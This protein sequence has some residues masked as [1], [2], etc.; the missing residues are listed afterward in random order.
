MSM[1]IKSIQQWVE[2]NPFIAYPLI[3]IIVLGLVGLLVTPGQHPMNQTHVDMPQ[4]NTPIGLG[5][6]GVEEKAYIT[7]LEKSSY[8]F[9][10]RLKDM[11]KQYQAMKNI[12]DDLKKKQDEMNKSSKER[13]RK[14]EANINDRFQMLQDKI[15]IEH[16]PATMQPQADIQLAIADIKPIEPDNNGDS[17][18][19][20]LGSFCKGTLLTGVYATADQNNPLPVLISLDEAFYGPNQTRIPLKG[21]FVLGK[22]YGDLVSE[23]ALIQIIAISSVLPSGITFENEQNLGYV[24]DAYGELGV[25]GQVIRNTGGQLA[26]TFMSGFLSGGSQALADQEVTVRRNEFGDTAREVTGNPAKNAVFE[27]LAKS[28]GHLSDYY[29]KQTENMVPAIHI[30]NGQQVYFIVQKGVTIDGLTRLNLS[31][32]HISD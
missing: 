3:G 13:D 7:R 19:L 28:A 29:A 24:T 30:S 23:R 25:R 16:L 22:A 4:S 11:Q 8:E 5:V 27:G 17:V 20:P 2:K 21:A 9:E 1:N 10:D 26:A 31:S 14:I 6:G 18:Y 32:R 12:A 15:N